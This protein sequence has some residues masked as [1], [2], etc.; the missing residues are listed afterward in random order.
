[1]DQEN[2]KMLITDST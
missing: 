1:M 2:D